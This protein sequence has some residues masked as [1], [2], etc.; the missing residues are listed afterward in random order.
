MKKF[1]HYINNEV[2]VKAATLNTAN[3]S[4]KIIAG[5]LISKCIAVYIGPQG[6]ALIGNLRN[7]LSAIQS[8]AISGLYNGVVKFISQFK[9]NTLEL[10]KTLSTVFYFGFFSSI[11]LAFLCYY[12]AEFINDLIFSTNYN[13]TYVVETL[14]IVLPF[15]ALNMFAFSIMNGFSKYKILL[16]INI[17]SQILGLLVTLLLIWQN[18]I[19]GALVAVVIA[20]ALNLLITIVGIAFRQNLMS[21]I[22]ITDIS[23]SILNKLSPYMIMALVSAIALPIVMII[24]RNY[25]IDEIGMK[26]AGYWTAMTR[27]SDYYLMFINSLMAL[28][29]LPRFAEINSRKAFRKEVFSFYKTIM[30][31]F[32]GLLVI[33]YFS[34]SFLINILFTEDFR[35]VEDLFGYQLLGDFIRVLSMVIAYQFLAKKM[36]AHFIILEVFLFVIM[37]FSSIYLIDIF[38]LKGAV[39]GHCLSY[40]MHFAIILLIFGSSLFGVLADQDMDDY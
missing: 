25:L 1:F 27:V 26:A 37:Y 9:T 30:P 18:N 23:F 20:P 36:F 15:Y 7:F 32:A 40:F 4:V 35:P 28:Y 17:I 31:V 34:R 12:N 19:D 14:S 3:I 5:I 16:I 24:I 21:S 6:M 22:K 33:I 2:L 39:M 8:I 13:Y 38:G 29:I 10:T 11:L